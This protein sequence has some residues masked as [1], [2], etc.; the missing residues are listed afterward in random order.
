MFVGPTQPADTSRDD[1]RLYVYKELN[2]HEN[3]GK[4]FADPL[5]QS[6]GTGDAQEPKKHHFFG[7]PVRK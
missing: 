4:S 2:D 6:D 5:H 3:S 1:S 7:F